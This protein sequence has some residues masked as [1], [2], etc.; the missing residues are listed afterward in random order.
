MAHLQSRVQRLT[1]RS[2]QTVACDKISQSNLKTLDRSFARP[3]L[4]LINKIPLAICGN[5]KASSLISCVLTLRTV[6]AG[7]IS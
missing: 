7:V 3:A 4:L 1:L 5:K 6:C 2:F